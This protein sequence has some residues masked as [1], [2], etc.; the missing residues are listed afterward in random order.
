MQLTLDSWLTLICVRR[1]SAAKSRND[2][3]I[4]D[5]SFDLLPALA[6]GFFDDVVVKSANGTEVI[7]D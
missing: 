5:G 3:C 6:E 4:V 2:F 1:R 7:S